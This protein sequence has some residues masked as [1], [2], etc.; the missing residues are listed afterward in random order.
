MKSDRRVAGERNFQCR[1]SDK[2]AIASGAISTD[3]DRVPQA[4]RPNNKIT[5][6]GCGLSIVGTVGTARTVTGDIMP[7]IAAT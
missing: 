1:S 5:E 6:R 3:G 2:A 4:R 7:E